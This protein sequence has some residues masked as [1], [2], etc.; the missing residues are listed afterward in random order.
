MGKVEESVVVGK[1]LGEMG[2]SCSE[3]ACEGKNRSDQEQL[4]I[5]ANAPEPTFGG[6]VKLVRDMVEIWFGRLSLAHFRILH[7]YLNYRVCINRQQNYE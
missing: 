4:A 7:V 3:I 6:F 5:E 1:A 2:G